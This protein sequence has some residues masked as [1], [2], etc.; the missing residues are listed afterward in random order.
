MKK[1]RGWL[2]LLY[3]E[4][5]DLGFAKDFLMQRGLSFVVS[6]LHDNDLNSDGEIK[7]AHYHILL[8]WDGPTTFDQASQF[9]AAIS[10]V[11]CI[12]CASIRGS[13]RYFYHADNPEKYQYCKDDLF[14]FGLDV[15]DLIHS[16]S[17]DLL[18]FYDLLAWVN[19]ESVF[20]FSKVCDYCI[21]YKPDWARLIFTKYR[22]N[23]W[24]YLRSLEYDYLKGRDNLDRLSSDKR[25]DT[26]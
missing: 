7:K 21:L 4:S 20:S 16:D 6:P 3:P 8:C 22:E 11:G 2:T 10:G 13:V 9:I 15:N 24:R 23:L 18:M 26:P 19:S 5:A 25:S 14:C 17:D 1:S 12:P